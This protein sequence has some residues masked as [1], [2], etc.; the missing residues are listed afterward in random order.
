M[1]LETPGGVIVVVVACRKILLIEDNIDDAFFL[2]RA[3]VKIP[4]TVGEF[5]LDIATTLTE[6]LDILQ[7]AQ[8]DVIL[9]DLSLPDS[10]GLN[11]V[12]TIINATK[13]PLVVMTG[14]N[15]EVYAQKAIALGAQDYLVKGNTDAHVL[16][17]T[18]NYAIERGQLLQ[19]IEQ[20]ADDRFRHII[21]NSID[22]MLV[23]G[24]DN[25]IKFNNPASRIFFSQDGSDLVG[26]EFT[27]P[28][29]QGRS[30]EFTVP[31]YNGEKIIGQMHVVEI[32]WE[33][34]PAFLVS[35]RDI[36]ELKK[37]SEIEGELRE[38]RRMDEL[39]DE[40]I[41][42]V[43]HELRT[44][45]GIVHSAVTTLQNP[46]IGIMTEKQTD[47]L[48]IAVRNTRR[49][50]Q[51]IDDLLDLS[52][53]ESHEISIQRKPLS[54]EPI[55]RETIDNFNALAQEKNILLSWKMK[56]TMPLMYADAELCMQ[57]MNNLMT[58]AIRFAKTHVELIAEVDEADPDLIKINI[59]DDGEGVAEDKI[60][61][62]FKKF[63]QANRAFKGGYQGTGLGLTISK[64]IMEMHDGDISVKN[65][66]TGACFTIR[67]KAYKREQD[68]WVKINDALS[69]TERS[70]DRRTL[71]V[72]QNKSLAR[73]YA[74]NHEEAEDIIHNLSD[75]IVEYIS[76][77]NTNI[78]ADPKNGY[79][80]I[81]T[82]EDDV[83]ANNMSV[84]IIDRLIHEKMPID[85]SKWQC[86][87]AKYPYDARSAEGLIKI[88]LKTLK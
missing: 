82:E 34:Q 56:G 43:S 55:F 1:S 27:H 57:V 31:G 48:D 83:E 29:K 71:I 70:A 9:L 12:K 67:F 32:I 78:S 21:E 28:L 88:A 42:T 64:T 51:L 10:S 30:I 74:V 8:P 59:I 35:I 41:S 86:G 24:P 33:R 58:N 49:L 77:K 63:F 39:K 85:N 4:A 65:L 26:L 53:L 5:T 68:K 36:T 46:K 15:D 7:T 17:R 72:F 18:I 37:L 23:I 75:H 11:G 45:L 84:K 19:R 44:P 79:V 38:H 13:I 6:A 14:M 54:I 69:L 66:P 62:I 47:I 50:K 60:S 20:S 25:I 87:F 40:F 2:K 16:H 3:L 22:G 61:H 80:L 76:D 52:R 81:L 73:T